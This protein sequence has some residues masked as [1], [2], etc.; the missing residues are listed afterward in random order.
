MGLIRK[1]LMIGTAGLVRGSSKKQRVA[2]AQLKELREQT[3]IMAEQ[4]RAEQQD[5][6]ARFAAQ[7]APVPTG[8]HEQRKAELDR[9]RAE[10][11]AIMKFPRLE[12]FTIR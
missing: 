10:V 1:S 2:K 5:R 12:G 3:R 9:I 7:Q 6:E 8:S 4:E 11:S